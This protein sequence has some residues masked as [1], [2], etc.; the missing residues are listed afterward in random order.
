MPVREIP[1]PTLIAAVGVL[2]RTRAALPAAEAV[3]LGLAA[4]AAV[5]IQELWLLT[6]H[7]NTIAHE[8]AHAIAG[9]MAGRKVRS[10]EIKRNADGATNVTSG[11]AAGTVLIAVAGYLGPSGFGLAAAKLISLGQSVTVLW[12]GLVLLF[13]VLF[14]LRKVFSFVP[15]VLTGLLL[16]IMARYAATGTQTVFAYGSTW[17]LLLAGVRQV[18]DHGVRA[19]DALALSKITHIGRGFWFWLWLAGTGYALAIGGSLLV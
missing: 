6:R 4:L 9:V 10:M 13:C 1:V 2:G 7:V 15:V 5:T 3:L 14:V 12:L 16:F 11:Q 18:L 17:F 19:S 8:G